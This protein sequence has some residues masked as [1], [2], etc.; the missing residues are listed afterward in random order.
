MSMSKLIAVFSH[1]YVSARSLNKTYVYV[2]DGSPEQ[3]EEFLDRV[4]MKYQPESGFDDREGKLPA[5]KGNPVHYE[6][7][8]RGNII[9]LVIPEDTEKRVRVSDDDFQQEL[10]TAKM[11]GENPRE[12]L[13][14]Y[15]K[16]LEK[17]R[18]SLKKKSD[19]T[20]LDNVDSL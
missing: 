11:L 3:H 16:S 9:E 15:Q 20:N 12:V 10:A 17:H 1:S 18:F 5:L 6:N 7:A 8:F 2:L 19:R 13:V 14:S 4:D